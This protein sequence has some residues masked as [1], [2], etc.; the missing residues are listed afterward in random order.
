MIETVA[1]H[2]AMAIG[3]PEEPLLEAFT[4]SWASP[5]A[6]DVRR[7]LA[8]VAVTLID[9]ESPEILEIDLSDSVRP[10]VRQVIADLGDVGLAVSPPRIDSAMVDAGP[11][12]VPL[13]R[14]NIPVLGAVEWLRSAMV[15]VIG[16]AILTAV[17]S[18][19]LAL[20]ADPHHVRRLRQLVVTLSA[21]AFS[22]AAVLWVV[23]FAARKLSPE[24]L[25]GGAVDVVF[26]R[27][28]TAPVMV[29]IIAMQVGI[30]LAARSGRPG[31]PGDPRSA[32]YDPWAEAPPPPAAPPARERQPSRLGSP[33][34][35]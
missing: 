4:E 11:T 5:A 35:P 1:H 2:T 24:T 19:A 34:R 26:S 30:M 28:L 16:L 13:D 12:P 32:D 17:G 29:G 15:V 23:S 3:A 18:A 9:A 22:V 20:L 8:T 10:L 7:Q 6:D 33:P 14:E 27:S 25:I 21:S 31:R